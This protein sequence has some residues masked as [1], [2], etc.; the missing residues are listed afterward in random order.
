M[1]PERK[2]DIDLFAVLKD[3]KHNEQGKKEGVQHFIFHPLPKVKLRDI[4]F[5]P[6]E[7]E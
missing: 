1:L 2:I 6:A 4:Q 5:R 7:V 3:K